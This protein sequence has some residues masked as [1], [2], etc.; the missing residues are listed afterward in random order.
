MTSC[1]GTRRLRF[2]IG[3]ITNMAP[4]EGERAQ[5]AFKN[6]KYLVEI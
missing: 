1:D 4:L 2:M 6:S 5:K 3:L